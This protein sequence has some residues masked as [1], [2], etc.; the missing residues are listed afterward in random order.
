MS[1]TVIECV[2][3]LLVVELALH[4]V[5]AE[6]AAH[7][8]EGIDDQRLLGLHPEPLLRFTGGRVVGGAAWNI[9]R[10]WLMPLMHAP[11]LVTAERQRAASVQVALMLELAHRL[12]KVLFLPAAAVDPLDDSHGEATQV[13]ALVAFFLNLRLPRVWHPTSDSRVTPLTKE[14]N[15]FGNLDHASSSLAQ[16]RHHHIREFDLLRS[17]DINNRMYDLMICMILIG[18]EN[19][20]PGI[21]DNAGTRRSS[22]TRDAPEENPKDS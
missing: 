12:A 2:I 20:E 15:G 18:L 19:V 9:E 11:E 3:G 14:P 21:L 7:G 1:D 8:E 13:G 16:D 6:V 22:A 5:C 10:L 4:T 17:E